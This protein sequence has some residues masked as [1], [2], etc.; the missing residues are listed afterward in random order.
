VS[1]EGV[2]AVVTLAY[3]QR[4]G[5]RF[6]DAGGMLRLRL[7]PYGALLVAFFVGVFRVAPA[8][9]FASGFVRGMVGGSAAAVLWLLCSGIRARRRQALRTD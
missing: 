2:V 9:G 3:A 7:V 8:D 6:D 1:V 5:V 4:L